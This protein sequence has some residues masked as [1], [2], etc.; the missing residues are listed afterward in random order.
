MSYELFEKAAAINSQFEIIPTKTSIFAK[1]IVI[2]N[3]GYMHYKG[4]KYIPNLVKLE[5][6]PTEL[7]NLFLEKKLPTET[8]TEKNT[9][10]KANEN[11]SFNNL[12]KILFDQLE[13][14][15]NPK[16]ETDISQELK[17]ANTIC[18]VADKIISIAD[19]SLKAEMFNYKKKYPSGKSLYQD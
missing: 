12:N 1:G 5:D 19:L 7:R 3:N 11:E 17:K 9:E 14:I 2:D 6:L 4:K 10:V 15:A 16:G 13:K 18:N 8:T